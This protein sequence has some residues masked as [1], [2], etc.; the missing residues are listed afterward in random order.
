MQCHITDD[1][2]PRVILIKHYDQWR[3]NKLLVTDILYHDLLD[4]KINYCKPW[5]QTAAAASSHYSQNSS[6]QEYFPSDFFISVFMDQILLLISQQKTVTYVKHL[7]L[8]LKKFISCLI[9][10]NEK[11]VTKK[12]QLFLHALPT[13]MF[14]CVCA[15]CTP[16]NQ[17]I[18][19]LMQMGT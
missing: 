3:D 18:Y 16:K 14:L 4:N 13:W 8:M 12:A 2:S 17:Y 6:E 7:W 5:E 1:Q 9:N 15:F 10:N 19:G 11:D